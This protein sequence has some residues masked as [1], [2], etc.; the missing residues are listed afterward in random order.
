MKLRLDQ[1]EAHVSP[2]GEVRIEVTVTNDGHLPVVPVLDVVGLDGGTVTG[3]EVLAASGPLAPGASATVPLSFSLPADAVAGNRRVAV[4]VDDRDGR[5]ARAMARLSLHTGSAAN[6]SLHVSPR[7]LR[8]RFGSRFKVV[9]HNHGTERLDL[10]VGGSGEGVKLRITPA[11][12]ELPPGQHA[13]LRGRVWSARP[14]LLREGRQPFHLVAQ[15]ATTPV[16]APGTLV[17]RPLLPTT[18]TRLTAVVVVMALWASVVG[19][20]IV[21]VNQPPADTAAA[22]GTAPGADG[23]G[24][25]AAEGGAATDGTGGGDGA[26]SA[27]AAGK[28]GEGA[29]QDPAAPALVQ[30]AAAVIAGTVSGPP[31]ASGVTV[32]LERVSIGDVPGSGAGKVAAQAPVAAATGSVLSEQRTVTD[33]GGRFRFVN[34]LEVP[35]L[36][37]VSASS[38]GYEVASVIA[39]LTPEASAVDLAMTLTPASGRL[40]GRVV[41]DD[42]RPIGGARITVF[43]SLV[44]YGARS[45]SDG[46][47]VG[48]WIVE[49]LHTPT[50]YVVVASADGYATGTTVVDLPG[51]GRREVELVLIRGQGTVRGTVS[52]RGAPVGGV[53]ITL[54]GVENGVTRTTTTLTATGVRGTFSLPALPLGRYD[55]TV[56]GDGWLTQ[57]RQIDVDRGDVELRIDD[58]RRSTA[59]IGGRVFQDAIA[60]CEYPSP[61]TRPEDITPQP[62]GNVGVRVADERATFSTTTASGTGAFTL[63]G[64][65]AGTYTVTFERY[66]YESATLSVTV[67]AGDIAELGPIVGT[68]RG[69]IL[70]RLPG[71]DS[72]GRSGARSLVR[73]TTRPDDVLDLA[74]L[75]P[76]L[77]LVEGSGVTFDVPLDATCIGGAGAATTGSASNGSAS[78]PEPPSNA[79]SGPRACVL[80]GGTIVLERLTPGAKVLRLRAAGFDVVQ[81]VAQ[82]PP[83]GVAELGVIKL[84]PLATLTGLVSGSNNAPVPG[85]RVFV[86]PVA[87]TAPMMADLPSSTDSW[88]TCRLDSNGDGTAEDGICAD[89]ATSGE[90]RLGRALGSGSYRVV[91]PV[92]AVTV[93]TGRPMPATPPA[94]SLDH[95]RR[96]RTVEV[97]A[98]SSFSVDLAL[99]RYGAVY[100]LLQ[101][102]VAGG[103]YR[104]LNGA[105][106]QIS[107]RA[108]G[109]P[110]GATDISR[111]TVGPDGGLAEGRYRVDRLLSAPNGRYELTFTTAGL[112]TET[113]VLEGGVAFNDELPRNVVLS[114]PPIR[115]TGTVVWEPHPDDP[116]S[117][118]PIAGAQVLLRGTTGYRVLEVSP[119]QEAVV[120]TFRS[121]TDADGRFG[122]EANAPRFV[123]DVTAA[124]L[125]PG[126][127]P[128]TASIDLSSVSS[129]NPAH[130][131]QL[132]LEPLRRTLDGTLRLVPAVGVGEPTTAARIFAE[133]SVTAT[134]TVGGTASTTRVSTA[135]AFA[136]SDLRPG[137]YEVTISGPSVRDVERTVTIAPSAVNTVVELPNVELTRFTT[138]TGTVSGKTA[139]SDAITTAVSGATVTV[140]DGTRTATGTTGTDGA[141]AVQGDLS[142]GTYDLT[143]T[144]NGYAPAATTVTVEQGRY[145]AADP[146]TLIALPATLD[147]TVW[148][149]TVNTPMPDAWVRIDELAVEVRTGATG[150][151]VVGDLPPRSYTVEV[152]ADDG[153][154]TISR[155]V[156]L[157]PGETTVLT[158]TSPGPAGTF[159]GVVDGREVADGPSVVLSGARVR[160]LRSG[161]EI[162]ST[163]TNEG[164]NFSFAALPVGSYTVE[165]SA[166]GYTTASRS[167][168]VVANGS[169]YLSTTLLAAGRTATVTVSSSAGGTISGV[170]VTATR[171]GSGSTEPISAVT[172]GSGIATLPNLPPGTWTLATTGGPALPDPH[173]DATGTSLSVSLGGT[174]ALTSSLVMNRYEGLTV[175]VTGRIGGTTAPLGG[176][177]VTA[178]R[179][180]TTLTLTETAAGTYQV[181]AAMTT[182]SWTVSAA[183]TGYVTGSTSVSVT[184]DNVSSTSLEVSAANRQ[185]TVTVVSSSGATPLSGVSVTALRSGSPATSTTVTTGGAGTAAFTLLPGT[186]TLSTTNATSLLDPHANAGG[187]SF[188]VDVGDAASALATTLTLDRY[189]GVTVTVTARPNAETAAAALT[190]ATVTA[191]PAGGGTAVTITATATAGTYAVRTPLAAGTWDLSVAAT[192]YATETTTITVAA[193][194]VTTQ[195]VLL[196][197]VARTVNVNVQSSR[198]P[199]TTGLPGVTVRA[200]RAGS[201][202][203]WADLTEGANGT[204]TFTLQPGTWTLETSGGPALAD[205]HADR[206]NVSATVAV[207]DPAVAVSLTAIALDRYEGVEVTVTGVITPDAAATAISDATVRLVPATGTPIDVPATATAGTY[208]VRTPIAPGSWTL[209]VTRADYATS[210]TAVTV[211]EDNVLTR[212]VTLTPRDRTVEVTVT[213]SRGA[214]LLENVNVRATRVNNPASTVTASTGSDGVADL[215]LPPGNWS[216]TTTNGASLSDPHVDATAVTVTVPVGDPTSPITQAFQL[217]RLEGL[218]LAVSGRPNPEAADTPLAGATVTATPS[219]G[220]TAVTLPTTATTGTYAVRTALAAGS[221]DLTVTAT[222]YDTETLTVTVATDEVTS[223][224]VVLT[225]AER[226]VTVAVQSSLGAAALAGVDVRAVRAG[227]SDDVTVVSAG[228]GI[229]TFTLAPGTWTLSTSGATLLADPHADRSGIS[230]SVPVGNPATTVALSAISLDRYEGA[231]VTVTGVA[232]PEAAATALSGATVTLTP[233]TGSPITVSESATAGTYALRAPIT[234]GTYTLTV[235]KAFY[236]TS[237][238]SVTI[239]ADAVLSRSVTL[240]PSNRTL[241]VTVSSSLNATALAGVV[242]VATRGG[243]TTSATTDVT[244]KVRLTLAVGNWSLTTT[245][246]TALGDPHANATAT[247]VVVPVGDAATDLTDALTLDRYEGIQIAVTARDNPTATPATFAG[248][249][250]VATRQGA[251]TDTRTLTATGVAGTLVV[252]DV[253]TPGEWDVTATATGYDPATTSVT[254]SADQVAPGSITLTAAVREFVVTVVSSSGAAPLAGV[255]VTATK[256]SSSVTGTTNASGVVRLAAHQGNNWSI[257]TTNATTLA[258]PHANGSTTANMPSNS[259]A[260]V[261]VPTMTLNRYEGIEAVVTGVDTPDGSAVSLADATVTYAPSGGGASVSVPAT[262]TTGT[263]RARGVIATGNYVVTVTKANYGTATATVSVTA[264]TIASANITLTPSNRTVTVTATSSAGGNLVGVAVVATRDNAPATT[265]TGTTGAGGTVDLTLPVGN[266]TLTTTNATGLADPHANGTGTAVAVTVGDPTVKLTSALTLNRYEGLSVTVTARPNAE[267]AATAFSGATVTATPPGGGAALTLTETGAGT[268]VY[269]VRAAMAAGSW[270]VTVSAGTGYTDDTSSVSVGVDAIASASVT[271]TADLRTVNVPVVSSAGGGGLVGVTVTATRSGATDVTAVTAAGGTAT[272]SLAPGSYTLATSGA[273]GITPPH[274]DTSGV[275]LTVAVG[276]A[277]TAITVSPSITLNAL[278][279][280]T[281]DLN[282]VT[283]LDGTAAALSGATV[284]ATRTAGAGAGATS[285]TLTETATAGRYRLTGALG[286]GT[287]ELA[288]SKTGYVAQTLTVTLAADG[289]GSTSATLALADRT[290]AVAVTSSPA[291]TAIEGARVIATRDISPT[292]TVSATSS[293]AG[294]ATL[295]LAPGNWTLSTDNGATLPTAGGGPGPH[296]DATGVALAV[297]IGNP[298]TNVTASVAMVAASATVTG[299]VRSAFPTAGS[300]TQGLEGA[301]VTA[302]RTGGPSSFA[303]TTTVGS[304]GAFSLALPPSRTW[305][306][307]VT[308]T[309]HTTGT[310]SV[311]SGAAASSTAAGNLDVVRTGASIADV[312]RDNS[313][314]PVAGVVVTYRRDG[315]PTAITTVTTDATGAHSATGLDPYA[316][317][318]VTF[319]ARNATTPSLR[320]QPLT[321][322]AT[323]TAPGQALTLPFKLSADAGGLTV[324]VTGALQGQSGVTGFALDS[325]ATIVLSDTASTPKIDD[326]TVTTT[327]GTVS[328]GQLPTG[329]S[330]KLAITASGYGNASGADTAVEITGIT[331]VAGAT[332]TQPVT[333]YP[334]PRTLTVTVSDADNVA[335]VGA[336]V[337]LTGGGL[338][339][340]GV[341]VATGTGGTAT[342]TDVA[343]STDGSSGNPYSALVSKSGYVSGSIA[344]IVVP[345]GPVATPVAVTE[346]FE[347]VRLDVRG[348]LADATWAAAT[349]LTGATITTTAP[350]SGPSLTEVG[351]GIYAAEGMLTAGSWSFTVAATGHD[352]GTFNGTVVADTVTTIDARMLPTARSVTVTVT[353]STT[354]SN[355]DGVTVRAARSG[356]TTVTDV[357]SS[358]TVTLSLRP[359]TYALTT[360][361]A[362]SLGDPHVDQTVDQTLAVPLTG[363]VSATITLSRVETV[364]VSVFE[365]GGTTP[366]TNATVTISQGGTTYPVPHV[367]NGLYRVRAGLTGTWTIVAN[368]ADCT[369]PGAGSTSTP[370]TP[371]ADAT[372]TRTITFPSPI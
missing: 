212:A 84:V 348:G 330:Y 3:G 80:S 195:P 257:T 251:P 269:A 172:N 109:L 2:G 169:H 332:T 171:T 272:L 13:R 23:S 83:S 79:P 139:A 365:F 283:T 362:S 291:G 245:G 120:E 215:A 335:V 219:G 157:R 183:T 268:G 126:F 148:D 70:L 57:T 129:A 313:D 322:T 12:V 177:T 252:R 35:G 316:T 105:D 140:T 367:S 211:T 266:W 341:T 154:A 305:T 8:G 236:G 300:G 360:T 355:L 256:G 366:V 31:D 152:G 328:I 281:V 170:T 361:G 27:S 37:R 61:G 94:V 34:G 227:S 122:T 62:C 329:T 295:T 293:A 44:T 29:P 5:S 184:A 226:T 60:N 146:I 39:S 333:L 113:V 318:R 294:T 279:S 176:A 342:F 200:L 89:V 323:P 258:D 66:G 124:L 192:G 230:A 107:V 26:T 190:G 344:S 363:P 186:W 73:D 280:L 150:N 133:L 63:S 343:V 296:E 68:G 144:A 288:V 9:L 292:T 284:A 364:E 202:D 131:V 338:S 285:G 56:T 290:V 77:Q 221:W 187:V 123:G 270:T 118:V 309:G 249:T 337:Q 103:G 228:S 254:V 28:T 11:R 81:I 231:T 234:A 67:G 246:A 85:A 321:L 352:D 91:A 229:A 320:R 197:A 315:D 339:A 312:V 208:A 267:T 25:P 78:C 155:I 311:T 336:S 289:S 115:V 147:V 275:A 58:L 14:A 331:V 158:L 21:K 206:A 259:S 121:T 76:S 166:N 193:D 54:D 16:G 98:G 175:T 97:Q 24:D 303:V 45:V 130:D 278:E 223:G 36:Y 17:Q 48:S 319:D 357:T 205:P 201:S 327:N 276:A 174:G 42:G 138:V 33:A 4:V 95:E 41:G 302:T 151:V 356:Q 217:D 127:T 232:T 59:T 351:G 106:V 274:A 53:T 188:V 110:T 353:S 55:V 371:T 240:T 32:L 99:R 93:P 71:I 325:E 216:V 233:T 196:T 82:I 51:G 143:V 164:G 298:A 181:R 271:L 238:A 340:G 145:V 22:A 116:T 137:T 314:N 180:G 354:S 317:Y 182:G 304:G 43:D 46:D 108:I 214:A 204:A 132:V 64:V 350:V 128:R 90:F 111:I 185:L 261:T 47:A 326:I 87:G 264:D 125:A 189:E 38:A 159:F 242:V 88:F 253:L 247:P 20:A 165:F 368:W 287:W 347:R 306:L 198:T 241:E 92:G 69:P 334:L 40:S 153:R 149:G 235:A 10:A 310:F 74:C 72:E 324:N 265:V 286:A 168:T 194:T 250:V 117:A 307:T 299:T 101:T 372:T 162:A 263:Y 225:G 224:V 96:E 218:T 173:A 15:G 243:T 282:G 359:A 104:L 203:D 244:G 102:P 75:R 213:S 112:R 19:A 65:P 134:P 178:T 349:P 179:S 255:S 308:A 167:L 358:G 237:T 273:T 301:T 52:S 160:V 199:P 207:G 18:L 248:A 277:A 156:N 370:V 239:T 49:G 119:F 30:A 1:Q 163:T 191:T 141:F 220:G 135:G 222:G 161:A 346:R 114:V 6:I 7:E 86:T 369:C 210:S 262:A 345:E 260:D 209:E 297:G 50:S 100:G 142:T 136:L